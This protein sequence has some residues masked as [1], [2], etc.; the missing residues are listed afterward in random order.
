MHI[1]LKNFE[2]YCIDKLRNGGLSLFE[3]AENYS[4]FEKKFNPIS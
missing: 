3:K 4:F 2:S 1:S